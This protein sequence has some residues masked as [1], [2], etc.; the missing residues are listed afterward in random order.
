M[1]HTQTQTGGIMEPP[2]KIIAGGNYIRSTL[3]TGDAPLY[4]LS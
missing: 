4:V 2:R 1:T 3:S